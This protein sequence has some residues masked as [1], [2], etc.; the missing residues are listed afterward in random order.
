MKRI[1]IENGEVRNGYEIE[2][3]NEEAYNYAICEHARFLLEVIID[4]ESHYYDA[5]EEA[6]RLRT[7]WFTMEILLEKHEQDIVDE[8]NANNYLFDEDGE[9]LPLQYHTKGNEIVKTLWKDKYNV[10]ITE[11]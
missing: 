10:K 1:E 3:L 2:E 11:V 8:I 5:V 6:E 7:P 9:L 4:E